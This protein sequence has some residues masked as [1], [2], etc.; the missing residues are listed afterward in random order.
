MSELKPIY[1]SPN[2][3]RVEIGKSFLDNNPKTARA[4]QVVGIVLAVLSVFASIFLLV[5][6]PIGLPIS[7]ALGGALLGLGGSMLFASVHSLANNM[8]RGAI[9][10]KRLNNI[11]TI[12][13]SE[14]ISPSNGTPEEIGLKYNLMVDKFSHLNMK[15]G[16]NEQSILEQIDREEGLELLESFNQITDNYQYCS[17]LLKEWQSVHSE[18]EFSQRDESYSSVVRKKE[19][20][21]NLGN[22]IISGLSKSGGV[23]SLKMQTLSKT[24]KKVHAG[25]TLGLVAG[26]IASVAVAAALIPGGLLALP[27]IVA[28]AIGIGIAVLSM[29]YAIKA[30]LKRSKTNKKQLLNDLKSSI[31]INL[32]KD[33]TR[34][35]DVLMGMLKLTLQADQTMALDRE[36]F[37]THYNT[38]QNSLQT[39]NEQLDEMEFMY[40][41]LSSKMQQDAQ[42]LEQKIVEATDA[43]FAQEDDTLHP[44]DLPSESSDLLSDDDEFDEILARGVQASRERRQRDR[45]GDLFIGDYKQHLGEEDLKFSKG[46]KPSGKRAIEKMWDARPRIM[47][48]E[49][50]LALYEDINQELDSYR[51]N[52]RTLKK[53]INRVETLFQDLQEGKLRVD[54]CSDDIIGIWTDTCSDCTR[55]LNQLSVMQMRLLAMIDY[56]GN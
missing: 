20:L 36:D 33:M 48:K 11:R 29:S 42:N 24:M 35:Q 55:I 37:Y 27:M 25:I 9:D 17:R 39:L 2:L 34:H 8:K 18:E 3:N 52:I 12:W 40:R 51:K 38:L 23:F 21:V 15:L 22:N 16:K 19:I 49:D 10:K 30:I 4:L 7:L 44:Q 53:D 46:W 26:G 32:L 43:Q 31:D 1:Q 45:A 13:R 47:K 50:Y 56:E 28:A 54:R 14:E 41:H 6:T 5:G